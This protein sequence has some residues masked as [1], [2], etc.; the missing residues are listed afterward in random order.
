MFYRGIV[1]LNKSLKINERLTGTYRNI[2]TPLDIKAMVLDLTSKAKTIKNFLDRKSSLNFLTTRIE[3]KLYIETVARDKNIYGHILYNLK[4]GTIDYYINFQDNSK[5]FFYIKAK[6]T[7]SL[8]GFSNS[9]IVLDGS[10]YNKLTH[11]KV[12]DIH[13]SSENKGLIEMFKNIKII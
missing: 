5:E 11:E 1:I 8:I 12:A 9:L 7:M 13:L 10:I 3:G 2:N 6:K 4:N